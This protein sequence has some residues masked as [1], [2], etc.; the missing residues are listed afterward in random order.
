GFDNK[1][2]LVA[3]QCAQ[4]LLHLHPTRMTMMSKKLH[5]K[6][7]WRK[8]PQHHRTEGDT[9]TTCQPETTKQPTET[10]DLEP[11]TPSTALVQYS[12]IDEYSS[13]LFD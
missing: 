7:Q 5:S 6:M 3:P 1:G 11:K 8:T 4:M 2:E 12:G 9:A 10:D 13:E